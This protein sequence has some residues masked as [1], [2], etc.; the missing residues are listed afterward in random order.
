MTKIA[1]VPEPTESGQVAY[2]A[3][4]GRQQSVGKTAGEALDAL[5]SLMAGQETG[6]VVIVQRQQPDE[7]FTAEQQ[8]RLKQL[9]RQWRLARDGGPALPPAEQ[10]ELEE[11]VGAEVRGAGQRAAAWLR[12]L[13]Q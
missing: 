7:F 1:I 2:R 6:A 13:E 10:A 8:R 12:E 4:A 3:I 11:L 9:M 5:S